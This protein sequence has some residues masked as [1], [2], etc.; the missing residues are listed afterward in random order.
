MEKVFQLSKKASNRNNNPQNCIYG[1]PLGDSYLAKNSN[2]PVFLPVM[3]E[4]IKTNICQE[5]VFR[6][7]GS[8]SMIEKL[9][10]LLS[11]PDVSIPPQATVHDVTGALK[12]WIRELPEPLIP[13]KL[14]SQYFMKDDKSTI[15]LI[16][17]NMPEIN[18]KAI[19]LIFS[20]ICQT[21][22]H[23]KEN[24]MT[25]DNLG[26]CLITSLVPLNTYPNNFNFKFFYQAAIEMLNADEDDFIFLKN[27]SSVPVMKAT[28]NT[29]Q[30]KPSP[31]T[32]TKMKQFDQITDLSKTA[33]AVR[34]RPRMTRRQSGMAIS[35][36]AAEALNFG[37]VNFY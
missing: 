26:P 24:R 11:C 1:L 18:R 28:F 29:K 23:E 10:L 2:V 5:G 6:L 15:S 27:L 31:R 34:P 13:P 7:N 14:V 4:F 9:G 30:L 22:E 33:P 20:L 17:R 19:A 36:D 32:P 35:P 21:I 37:D 12:K 16:L 25:Y 3:C 8:S